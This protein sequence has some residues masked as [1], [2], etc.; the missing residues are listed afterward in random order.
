MVSVDTLMG[1]DVFTAKWPKKHIMNFILL[2]EFK[3][4]LCFF[5]LDYFQSEVSLSEFSSSLMFRLLL[6]FLTCLLFLDFI[7]FFDLI[8]FPLCGS[9][10]LLLHHLPVPLLTCVHVI[11]QEKV[12]PI[13][14]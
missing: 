7:H 4:Q 13:V 6:Q 3:V 1:Q 11:R 14:R 12:T 8:F 2:A 5:S 9:P 10:H